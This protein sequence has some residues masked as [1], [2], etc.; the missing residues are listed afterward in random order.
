MLSEAIPKQ[1]GSFMLL[2]TI[3]LGFRLMLGQNLKVLN[4]ITLKCDEKGG[5]AALTVVAGE[6]LWEPK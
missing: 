1:I 5:G 2:I 4:K 6:Q 3:C